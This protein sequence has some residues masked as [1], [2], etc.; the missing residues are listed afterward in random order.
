MGHLR[1]LLQALATNSLVV[2]IKK[3]EFGR[4]EIA[5]LGHVISS[6]GVAVDM[7][8]VEA[9]LEGE[10]PKNLR[11]LRGF[12]GLTGYYRKF[13]SRYAQIAKPLTEQLKKDCFGWSDDATKAFEALK[14]A[15]V[16][17]PVLA[18]PNFQQPFVI[19]TD[20][21]GFG[22]EAVLMQGQQPL[23]FY[24]KFLGPRAQLKSVYEKELMAVCLAVQKWRHYLL[25]HHF[26][27]RTDQQSLCYIMQQREVGAE[28]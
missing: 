25:G 15:M 14:Q 22:L 10:Q 26:V 4:M 11:E 19:E 9:M 20:A 3:C 5:Y 24:S 23:A 18:M 12:L 16:T 1:L 8:K 2:N 7:E 17:A 6:G 21:S 27:I 13:I 28:F